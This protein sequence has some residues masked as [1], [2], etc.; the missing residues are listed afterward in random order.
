MIRK[1]SYLVFGEWPEI[2]FQRLKMSAVCF[3]FFFV[4]LISADHSTLGKVLSDQDADI[5]ISYVGH[6]LYT[7]HLIIRKCSEAVPM[8]E[9]ALLKAQF[10]AEVELRSFTVPNGGR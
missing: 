8:E 7:A 2:F 6:Q 9:M 5:E 10:E 1:G 3:F 4:V